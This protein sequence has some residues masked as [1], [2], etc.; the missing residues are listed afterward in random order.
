MMTDKPRRS[1]DGVPLVREAK[2]E[3]IKLRQMYARASRKA[4]VQLQLGTV[5][6]EFSG[7]TIRCRMIALCCAHAFNH[8]V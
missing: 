8:V 5:N 4:L 6:I 7:P 1:S 3:G 2:T